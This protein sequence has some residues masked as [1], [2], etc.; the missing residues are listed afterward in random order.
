MAALLVRI[1]PGRVSNLA[2]WPAAESLPFS[3]PVTGQD[4]DQFDEDNSIEALCIAS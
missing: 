1:P 2:A 4:A 3:P